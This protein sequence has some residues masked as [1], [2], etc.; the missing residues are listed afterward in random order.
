MRTHT[1]DNDM[2]DARRGQSRAT[3]NCT[4][5]TRWHGHVGYR[6]GQIAQAYLQARA[7]GPNKATLANSSTATT[8]RGTARLTHQGAKHDTGW[9]PSRRARSAGGGNRGGPCRKLHAERN[10]CK[11]PGVVCCVTTPWANRMSMGTRTEHPRLCSCQFG[12]FGSLAMSLGP[13]SNARKRLQRRAATH[14]ERN[15][16]VMVG[17]PTLGQAYLI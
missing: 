12:G 14:A 17:I 2:P 13:W 11:R 16:M 5:Q 10:S 1:R 9:L 4:S 8:A 7:R 6:L 15:P 3:Q